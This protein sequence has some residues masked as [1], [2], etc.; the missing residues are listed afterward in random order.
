MY[1]RQFN[2]VLVTQKHKYLALYRYKYGHRYPLLFIQLYAIV[3]LC[4]SMKQQSGWLA[5]HPLWISP[6][7]FIIICQSSVTSSLSQSSAAVVCL[8][9]LSTSRISTSLL[10]T[11]ASAVTVVRFANGSSCAGGCR[12]LSWLHNAQAF[13]AFFSCF[14]QPSSSKFHYFVSSNFSSC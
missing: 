5:T 2:E 13:L 6:C 11:D 10:L 4:G 9:K 14:L 3:C 8:D 1:S 12:P 7:L